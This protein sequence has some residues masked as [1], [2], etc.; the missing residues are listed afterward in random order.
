MTLNVDAMDNL[1]AM[2]EFILCELQL[3][4]RALEFMIAMQV[5]TLAKLATL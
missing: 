5:A 1:D 2:L 4:R 3:Q